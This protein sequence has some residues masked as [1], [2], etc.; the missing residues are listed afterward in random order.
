MGGKVGTR[1]V[2]QQQCLLNVLWGLKREELGR[3]GKSNK[4]KEKSNERKWPG[5]LKEFT[6]PKK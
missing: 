2:A 1:I 3:K 4:K 6:F 5:I